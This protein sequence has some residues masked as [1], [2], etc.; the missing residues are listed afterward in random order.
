MTDDEVGAI[1]LDKVSVRYQVP[2]ENVRNLKE[3]AIRRLLR[4]RTTS[5][6]F[7]ALRD[8][9]L[10]VPPGGSLGIVGHNGAGKS[11]L[12]KVISR[13]IRPTSG[14]VRV[15][16]RVA[17]LLELGTG[18]DRELT[19]R[20]N[21]FL[22]GMMLG[23]TRKDIAARFHRIVD[24]A[25]VGEFIDA[26]L[27]TYSTGMVARLAFASATDVDPDVLLID[28][29]LGVGDVDFQ[30]RSGERIRALADRGCA[31]VIVSH[32]P[33]AIRVMCTHAAWIEH[34]QV[35][36]SGPTGGVLE[37]YLS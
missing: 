1:R 30:K 35:R 31:V 19:G 9:D 2:H 34:G 12:L 4:A 28:E 15:R 6:A 11:T 24:F 26:P 16:G 10:A 3:Y 20:E 8:V 37:A 33:E 17:S 5:S 27:R 36:M 32:N 21:V 29:I 13:V 25:G 18:F 14:R 22:N 23:F 7:W